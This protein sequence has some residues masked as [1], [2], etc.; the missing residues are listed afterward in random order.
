M[1]VRYVAS[2]QIVLFF[3]HVAMSIQSHPDHL[4]SSVS[5]TNQYQNDE[6]E[7]VGVYVVGEAMG[8][9]FGSCQREVTNRE[10]P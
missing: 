4:T 10:I 9:Y 3:L 2:S 5:E 7:S 1:A 6:R 8:G